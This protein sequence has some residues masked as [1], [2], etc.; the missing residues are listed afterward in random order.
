[1]KTITRITD[2]IINEIM[3]LYPER[4]HPIVKIGVISMALTILFVL[5][6][7]VFIYIK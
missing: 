7:S 4:L 3:I 6:R 2:K 1:M 5:V